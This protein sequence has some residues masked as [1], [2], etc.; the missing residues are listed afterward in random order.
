MFPQGVSLERLASFLAVATAKG[1]ARAAPGNP[2]RQ[3]QLSRQVSE[4]QEALGGCKLIERRGRGVVVT[5]AGERL[6]TAVRAL[7]RDLDDLRGGA[8]DEPLRFTLGAGDSLL[9]W[10]VVP[11]LAE[12]LRA[13]APDAVPQL[14]ALASQDI[15][16]Q[17]EDGRLDFGLVRAREVPRQLVSRPLGD[18]EYA[19]YVP[20]A[21]MPKPLP[22]DLGALLAFL[23]LALQHSEDELN[24]PLRKL[25]GEHQLHAALDCETFPQALQAVR[26]G[27]YAA[28]LPTIAETELRSRQVTEVTHPKLARLARR[29]HL[30]WH[31]RTARRPDHAR[32][33]DALLAALDLRAE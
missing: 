11:R 5:A 6:A 18:L 19:L 8:A 7:A 26:S 32:L 23:P 29:V 24:E 30:A 15:V 31:P 22:G 12:G 17:L 9:Q 27:R 14:R 16:A 13:G 10:W 4:L 21:R 1:F 20:R 3:S 33:V 2:V 28:L 25:A